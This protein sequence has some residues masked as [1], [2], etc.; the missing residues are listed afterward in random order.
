MIKEF[1]RFFDYCSKG[2]PSPAKQ[3]LYYTVGE[4]VWRSTTVWPPEGHHLKRW[5]LGENYAL[6]EE[7]PQGDTGRDNYD[8]D[9][10]ATS[11]TKSRWFTSVGQPIE[12][13][14]RDREGQKLLT[15]YTP[16]FAADVEMTGHPIVNIYLSSTHEDG[17]LIA[18]VEDVDTE[19][20]VHYLTEGSMR[21]VNRKLADNPLYKSIGP[22]HS[23][24]RSDAIPMIPGEVSEIAFALLPISVV[25]KKGHR[26]R[27]GFAGAD[28]DNFPRCPKT[29]VPRLE[30]MRN[31]SYP[32]SVD[33]PVIQ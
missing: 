30:F 16:P 10:T 33:I 8:V 11:G 1:Y 27:M 19:G 14:N 6:S 21:L 17:Y 15:Y 3:I 31:A 20:K 13:K 24:L 4:E 23:L 32:S 2:N 5:F 7:A 29:G 12:Y 18:Y 22:Q 25:I 9:F 28:S 26:L